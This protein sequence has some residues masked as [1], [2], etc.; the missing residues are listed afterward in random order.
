[1]ERLT[2]DNFLKKLEDTYK[3]AIWKENKVVPD[4]TPDLGRWDVVKE[5]LEEFFAA[6][7]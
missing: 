5:V 3:Q 1:L 6:V 7:K 2:K 4:R